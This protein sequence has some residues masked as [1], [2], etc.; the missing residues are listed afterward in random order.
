MKRCKAEALVTPCGTP[1]GTRCRRHA[2]TRKGAREYSWEWNGLVACGRARG[3]RAEDQQGVEARL[4]L[5][6]A[7]T[8]SQACQWP[9]SAPLWPSGH[10]RSTV[11]KRT[12]GQCCRLPFALK[13]TTL[14]LYSRAGQWWVARVLGKRLSGALSREGGDDELH[15]E[16]RDGLRGEGPLDGLQPHQHLTDRRH[17]EGGTAWGRAAPLAFLQRWALKKSERGTQGKSACYKDGFERRWR[18]TQICGFY[19]QGRPQGRGSGC[20]PTMKTSRQ[21]VL[22]MMPAPSS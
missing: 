13:N 22:F 14:S 9:G 2:G 15:D 8:S 10:A 18:P 6:V 12:Q 3:P 5:L 11:R 16:N 7:G 19:P 20:G 1:C 21:K 17:T 4:H